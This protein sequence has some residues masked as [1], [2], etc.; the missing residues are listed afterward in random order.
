MRTMTSQTFDD[1]GIVRFGAHAA[2]LVHQLDS[3][4]APLLAVTAKSPGLARILDVDRNTVIHVGGLA[5][6]TQVISH[7]SRTGV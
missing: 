7:V 4:S 3:D 5:A 6:H 2:L 1:D